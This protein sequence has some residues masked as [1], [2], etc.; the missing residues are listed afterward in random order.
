MAVPLSLGDFEVT[1]SPPALPSLGSIFSDGL[2]VGHAAVGGGGGWQERQ[3]ASSENFRS[4]RASSPRLNHSH[5]G[6]SLHR[7]RASTSETGSFS[8]SR[9]QFS[10][11][12]P[13][14]RGRTQSAGKRTSWDQ[15]QRSVGSY[16]AAAAI[17]AGLPAA[18]AAAASRG[19]AEAKQ[20][21]QG[22]I[23]L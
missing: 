4:R 1:D 11:G 13:F 17:A 6:S 19:H 7:A 15:R 10:V 21:E 2:T 22:T 23:E 20:L 5:S 3:R 9:G 12:K 8:R 18:A 14:E 16:D